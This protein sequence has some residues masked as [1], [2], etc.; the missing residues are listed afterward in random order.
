MAEEVVH[1]L[2]GD[3]AFAAGDTVGFGGRVFVVVVAEGLE[4]GKDKPLD[5]RDHCSPLHCRTGVNP[6]SLGFDD[7]DRL[8]KAAESFGRKPRKLVISLLEAHYRNSRVSWSST[9]VKLAEA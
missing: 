9:E 1:S 8:K 7:R 5:C 4:I 6:W 2:A 3:T